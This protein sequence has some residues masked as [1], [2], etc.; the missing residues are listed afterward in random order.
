M[1][2]DSLFLTIKD[3]AKELGIHEITAY[4]LMKK[5]Q[6]PGQKIGGMWRCKREL[7]D[8]FIENG[9]KG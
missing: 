1:T 3:V 4:R 8:Q 9:H 5:K 7:L 6:I 2:N